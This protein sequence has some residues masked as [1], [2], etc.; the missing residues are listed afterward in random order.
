MQ[1]LTNLIIALTSLATIIY[2]IIVYVG[3]K[4]K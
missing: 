4:S 3:N 2:K 1:D